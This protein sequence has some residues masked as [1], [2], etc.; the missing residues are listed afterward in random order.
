MWWRGFLKLTIF[1]VVAIFLYATENSTY[2]SVPSELQ[3]D[4]LVHRYGQRTLQFLTVNQNHN[5]LRLGTKMTRQPD[6]IS[7]PQGSSYFGP[8]L[9]PSVHFENHAV[10]STCFELWVFHGMQTLV[11]RLISSEYYARGFRSGFSCLGPANICWSRTGQSCAV[12]F[13]S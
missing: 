13:H 8:G 3:Q 9:V 4:F 2:D 1:C 5:H 10:H 12:P 6:R 7:L 11:E